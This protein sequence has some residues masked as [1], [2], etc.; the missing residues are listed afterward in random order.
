MFFS[1]PKLLLEALEVLVFLQNKFN[2]KK[3]KKG[4]GRV[5]YKKRNV[6]SKNKRFLLH[7]KIRNIFYGKIVL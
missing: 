6:K 7:I 5:R 4:K 3:K 1:H 2:I